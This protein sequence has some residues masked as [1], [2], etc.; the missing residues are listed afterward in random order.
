MPPNRRSEADKI[1]TLAAAAHEAVFLR[2]L[3]EGHAK[4]W[5]EAA[6]RALIEKMISADPTNDDARRGAAL[7]LRALRSVRQMIVNAVGTGN[8]ANRKLE[9]TRE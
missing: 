9:S 3:L 1:D 6:E 7:E 5:F 4:N 2:P 8:Y